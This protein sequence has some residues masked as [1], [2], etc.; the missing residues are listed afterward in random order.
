LSSR[1]TCGQFF[2][3]GDFASRQSRC[4]AIFGAVSDRSTAFG[5][6]DFASRRPLGELSSGLRK[7]P[8]LNGADSSTFAP[9]AETA[10][11]GGTVGRLGKVR[12]ERGTL[13]KLKNLLLVQT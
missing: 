5:L 7:P 12:A 1:R 11:A 13:R 2:N 9:T 4:W 6:C 3:R 10:G 8:K